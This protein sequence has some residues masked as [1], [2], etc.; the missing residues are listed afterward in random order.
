MGVSQHLRTINL[1]PARW[2]LIVVSTPLLRNLTAPVRIP[3]VEIIIRACICPPLINRLSVIFIINKS[4]GYIFYFIIIVL[5][6][7][8]C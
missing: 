7:A 2:R 4:T 5:F 3:N 6:Q 1:R 8:F